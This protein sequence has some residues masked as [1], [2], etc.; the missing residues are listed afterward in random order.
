VIRVIII[1]A[2]FEVLISREAQMAGS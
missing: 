2:L 1:L